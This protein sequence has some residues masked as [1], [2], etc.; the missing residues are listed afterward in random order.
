MDMGDIIRG[1]Q[2][3]IIRAVQGSRQKYED[4]KVAGYNAKWN[5]GMGIGKEEFRTVKNAISDI[6]VSMET[7][8]QSGAEKK[9]MDRYLLDNLN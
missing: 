7:T 8:T 5:S 2:D 1:L 4:I 6:E 9:K 3:K